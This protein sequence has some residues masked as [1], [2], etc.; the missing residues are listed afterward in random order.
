MPVNDVRDRGT[1]LVFFVF[2]QAVCDQCQHENK[3]D[4]AEDYSQAPTWV[5]ADSVNFSSI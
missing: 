4:S 2:L 3:D 1:F 5:Y